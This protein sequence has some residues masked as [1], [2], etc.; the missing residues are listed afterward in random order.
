MHSNC[1][2]KSQL[3]VLCSVHAL[4]ML[5]VYNALHYIVFSEFPI[6]F[7]LQRPWKIN[8]ILEKWHYFVKKMLTKSFT[9]N[10][11]G[12]SL[13]LKLCFIWER[14]CVLQSTISTRIVCQV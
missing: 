2:S 7:M 1:V 12:I 14:K 5:L 9:V 6:S 3:C 10:S 13:Y 4:C 8:A 11:E